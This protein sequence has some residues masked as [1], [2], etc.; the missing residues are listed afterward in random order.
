MSTSPRLC[1]G[2]VT[3]LLLVHFP[4]HAQGVAPRPPAQAPLD[5]LQPAGPWTTPR[6]QPTPAPLDTLQPAGAGTT[7]RT[8]SLVL[9]S[10][11]TGGPG[12]I[13][14]VPAAV[15]KALD[16][17]KAFL[18][19]NTYR[20][21]DGGIIA[22]PS[23]NGLA[24]QRL[25]GPDGQLFEVH[26]SRSREPQWSLD[27]TLR[28]TGADARPSP[29]TVSPNVLIPMGIASSP[30]LLTATVRLTAGE[31]IVVGTSRVRGDKAL[32]LLLTGLPVSPVPSR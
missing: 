32:I 1:V 8:L 14:E 18:P 5:T 13:D 15:R 19:F 2:L 9:L 30:N 24:L 4:L 21:H 29:G 25:R 27:V 10:G 16:D 28:E 26:M 3:A 11:E 20:L 12:T 7:L 31:T 22:A 23:V 6:R 17:L